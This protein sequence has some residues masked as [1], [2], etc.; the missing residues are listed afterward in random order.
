MTPIEIATEAVSKRIAESL[1][2]S[3]DVTTIERSIEEHFLRT[4]GVGVDAVYDAS[5]KSVLVTTRPIECFTSKHQLVTIPR[6]A[7]SADS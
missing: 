4:H 7:D 1:V 3:V 2:G 5:E 6:R